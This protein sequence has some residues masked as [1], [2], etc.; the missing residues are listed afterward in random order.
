MGS[1]RAGKDADLVLWSDN[2]LSV[3]ARA[4]MTFVDGIPVF[5]L[6]R[7]NELERNMESERKRII[8]KMLKARQAGQ[9][10]NPPAVKVQHLWHCDDE[11]QE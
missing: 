1:I 10:A 4:E 9:P 5:S 3:R 2:P 11:G 8:Q 7:Q 6:E